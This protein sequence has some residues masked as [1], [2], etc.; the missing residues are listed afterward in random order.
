MSRLG[1]LVTYLRDGTRYNWKCHLY[2]GNVSQDLLWDRSNN[3]W[4][5]RSNFIFC[6]EN[7]S[8]Y[9]NTNATW[10]WRGLLQIFSLCG[11]LLI[12]FWNC[13][14]NFTKDWTTFDFRRLLFNN[15]YGIFFVEISFCQKCMWMWVVLTKMV[16]FFLLVYVRVHCEHFSSYFQMRPCITKIPILFLSY[17]E[18][19]EK[20]L[21]TKISIFYLF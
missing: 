16:F 13:A 2:S 4:E 9:H 3:G 6:A 20:V 10:F 21:S 12:T 8:K 5:S 18:I 14:D 15:Y 11:L 17:F 7:R 19:C 1:Y